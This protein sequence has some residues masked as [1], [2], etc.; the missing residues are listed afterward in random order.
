M[1]QNTKNT[2][3]GIRK[4]LGI[5]SEDEISEQ[6]G[7][8]QGQG[9]AEA[10]TRGNGAIIDQAYADKFY[11]NPAAANAGTKVPAATKTYQI[12]SYYLKNGT[13]IGQDASKLYVDRETTQ[14]G[15]S[16]A[17]ASLF[18]TYISWISRVANNG[19]QLNFDSSGNSIIGTSANFQMAGIVAGQ[20]SFPIFG[21]LLRVMSYQGNLG[22]AANVK[23]A[24]AVSSMP[25]F[26]MQQR[27]S[28]K[29]SY[30][31]VPAAVT[32]NTIEEV[33][34]GTAFVGNP[35]LI[36]DTGNLEQISNDKVATVA[37]FP[38]NTT[39]FNLSGANAQIIILPLFINDE[40]ARA[41]QELLLSGRLKEFYYNIINNAEELFAAVSAETRN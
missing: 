7:G 32:S 23:F 24:G 33:Q 36:T 16:A 15:F 40:R 10:Q 17:V 5:K 22:Q 13:F 14:L 8:G 35:G 38:S 26:S 37:Q 3:D 1:N 4:M 31:L 6:K 12:P 11:N 9:D 21:F 25:N 28:T 41:F 27:D 29:V 34:T 30:I 2:L 19:Y 20:P 18:S 39:L